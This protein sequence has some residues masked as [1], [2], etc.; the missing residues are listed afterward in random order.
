MAD[1]METIGLHGE[2]FSDAQI[3]QID[4]VKDD[5]LHV[6]ATIQVLMPRINRL[7]PVARMVAEVLAQ[8]QKEQGQ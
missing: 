3:A 5:A 4:A 6:I 8:H 1:F 2:G 7:I